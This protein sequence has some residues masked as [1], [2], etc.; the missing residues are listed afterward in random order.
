MS[1]L[2]FRIL[3]YLFRMPAVLIAL[4]VHEVCH[5][6]VAYKLGDTTARDM[7]R[8]SLNPLRHLTPLGCIC[9]IFLGFGFA[10][11]VP[12]NTRYFEHP[13]RDMALTAIAG[14][15][16]NLCL[17][18]IAILLESIGY[19]ILGAVWP[20]AAEM[21]E[22]AYYV[23]HFIF[24]FIQTFY[25]LNLS[26]AVFNMIPV[27]PLDGSRVLYAFLPE[28]YYFG[29]M[30]YERYIMLAMF[31]LIWTGVLNGVLSTAVIWLYNAIHSAVSLLPFL[32]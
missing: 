20:N 10:K 18:I 11:P 3:P 29:V 7:G 6:L 31:A 32:G 19:A 21:S 17:A 16:S 27:P 1:D 2:I 15:I 30:R 26:L 9:M 22:F 12:I 4:T 23:T 14:P 13:K 8:L 24:Y 28:K 5:G 25:L